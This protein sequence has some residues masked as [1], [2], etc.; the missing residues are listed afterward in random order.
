V[1]EITDSG[2]A[3]WWAGLRQIAGSAC[4]VVVRARVLCGRGR[5]FWGAVDLSVRTAADQL[6][7]ASADRQ[8]GATS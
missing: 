4:A 1:P 6:N 3:T 7:D 5:T 8:F 2:A